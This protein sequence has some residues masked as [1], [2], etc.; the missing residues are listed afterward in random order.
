MSEADRSQYAGEVTTYSENELERL[1]NLAT[2]PVCLLGGWA[3]HLHVAEA[4]EAEYDRSYIGSRDIDLGVF[5]DP[6]W[7]QETLES[8]AVAT[9]IQ[10][11]ES[12]MEYNRGRFGFYRYFHRETTEALDDD[13]AAE[14]PQHE[15]FRLDIDII[16]STAKLDSFQRVFG[17]QPPAEPLLQP[18]FDDDRYEE[19]SDYVDWEIQPKGVRLV[20]RA[21]LAA[22]KVRSY[23]RRDKG[24]KRLKDLADLHA[25]IWYGARYQDIKPTIQSYLDDTDIDTFQESTSGDVLAQAA[26]LLNIDEDVMTSSIRQLF[27]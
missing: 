4:F 3:V 25:L 2:P 13:T 9:T 6:E 11:I 17:F 16:P 27:V 15:I 26:G 12:E 22:M 10:D 24:H 1:L 14:Y 8:Q 20:P 18:V 21:I 23:P 5:I 19:L 7:S